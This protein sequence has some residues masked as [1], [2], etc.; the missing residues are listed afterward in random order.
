MSVVASIMTVITSVN[1][2]ILLKDLNNEKNSN[3]ILLC[4]FLSVY[5]YNLFSE[6]LEI[7]VL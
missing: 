7:E 1:G 2:K 6:Y 4:S 5:T 3:C